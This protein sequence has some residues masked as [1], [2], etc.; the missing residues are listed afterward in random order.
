MGICE[1]DEGRG[2]IVI[3]K[4]SAEEETFQVNRVGG[5]SIREGLNSNAFG[6]AGI[7]RAH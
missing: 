3:G 5:A 4:Y 1:D 2:E 6:R 7:S